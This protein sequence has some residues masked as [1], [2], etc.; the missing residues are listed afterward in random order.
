MRF[1]AGADIQTQVRRIASGTGEV[2]AAVA[3]WG[4][5]AAER[6]GLTEHDRPASVRVICD[7]LSGACNPAEIEV[8]TEL[9]VSVK[10][11]DRLHAKVWICGDDVIV[12]SAN[13]SRN[14]LP[15]EGEIGAKANVEAAVLSQDPR[16]AHELKTWFEKQWCD[17]DEIEDRHLEQ[18]QQLWKRRRRSGGRGFTSTLTEKIP[19]PGPLDRFSNLRLI[20][21][22]DE[23]ATPEA[24]KFV[25]QNA[26]LYYTD[27]EWQDFGEKNPWYEW[28][29]GDLDR[30][31]GPGTVFMDFTCSIEGGEFTFNG[32]WEMRQ[33]PNIEL[34][35]ANIQLTLLTELPHFNGYSLSPE[36]EAAIALKIQGTVTE[37][38][39]Q[40]DEFGSYID[41]H[42][43][44]FWDTERAAL[45]Q[46][47]LTQVVEAARELCHIGQFDPSLT[48]RAIRVCKEEPEWLSGYTRFV[49]GDIYQHGNPLKRQINPNFG[50]LVKDGV[51]ATV[52][53]D[54]NGRPVTEE[55]EDEIIQS[56]TLFSG[57][58]S[59]TVQTS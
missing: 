30:S 49:G 27:K 33:C 54:E 8:L 13:A 41:E 39:H 43:L 37:R 29:L 56:Y 12:G 28:P 38:D 48:L 6:T 52:R 19:N 17:S 4:S 9:G 22:L 45:R 50:Q 46:Q 32:F 24:E 55:V 26:G 2:M 53:K 16:L 59:A 40:T 35:D 47:L 36:E 34:E 14:G 10:T 15:G 58:E 3:Y 7:L 31:H 5:G 57:Y 51:G 42:F 20:A 21:Y 11:L 18:A 1:L 23:G 44:E 25:G